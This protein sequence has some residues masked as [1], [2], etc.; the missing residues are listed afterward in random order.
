VNRTSK[1]EQLIAPDQTRM[2]KVLFILSELEDEDVE[3]IA[4]AGDRLRYP[5]GA[6][7]IGY[8]SQP[9]CV[10]FVLDGSFSVL[11]QN[12]ELIVEL[13]T[14]EI[15]GEMSLVDPARTTAA[16]RANEGAS[17]LRLSHHRLRDKLAADAPFAA[18]FYRALSVFL[19]A[20]MRETTRRLGYGQPNQPV[21]TQLDQISEELLG[22]AHLASLRFDRLLRRMAS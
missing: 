6:E 15:V 1:A 18:R 13:H 11:N 12:G 2:R 17:V 10:Y 3:W 5:V 8:D 9:D 20:R 22:K 14:G 19:A 21:E 4:N 16:V 7:I